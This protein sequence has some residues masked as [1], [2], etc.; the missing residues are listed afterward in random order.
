MGNVEYFGAY[1]KVIS[2]VP[3]LDNNFYP[4]P[5][6]IKISETPILSVTE[7]NFFYNY[8]REAL[9]YAKERN[10]SNLVHDGIASRCK[11]CS[12]CGNERKPV[13]KG[14]LQC[15]SCGLLVQSSP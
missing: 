5:P 15:E 12:Y 4:P 1:I 11:W 2:Y 8:L 9:R 7:L 13:S 10:F 14:I 6:E 3:S